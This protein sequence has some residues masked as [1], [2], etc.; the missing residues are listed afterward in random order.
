MNDSNKLSYFFLGLGIG[1]AAGVLF[2]PKSG[3]ETREYLKTKADE[4]SEY[5]RRHGETLKDSAADLVD[6]SKDAVHRQKEQISAAVEAGKKAYQES[7]VSP[8]GEV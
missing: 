4:G 8:T 5:L 3:P 2:A 1:V 7:V 6:R